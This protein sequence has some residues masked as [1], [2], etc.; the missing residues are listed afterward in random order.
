MSACTL[1]AFQESGVQPL[2]YARDCSETDR[3]TRIVWSQVGITFN[4]IMKHRVPNSL[5]FQQFLEL[6]L[7]A[8]SAQ[9]GGRRFL[10]TRTDTSQHTVLNFHLMSTSRMAILNYQFQNN[11]RSFISRDLIA[12]RLT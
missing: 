7:S 8:K 11:D 5:M 9:D 2:F 10:A 4:Q 12:L 1:N 3:L 6:N